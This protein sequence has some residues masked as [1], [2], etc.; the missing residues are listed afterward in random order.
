M[1]LWSGFGLLRWDFAPTATVGVQSLGVGGG[2]DAIA[3]T[4]VS[5]L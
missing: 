3:R 1:G 4:Q 2:L 5:S